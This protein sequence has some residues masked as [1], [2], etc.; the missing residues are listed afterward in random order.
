LQENLAPSIEY[1]EFKDIIVEEITVTSRD[2]EQIPLSLIY[3]K[4]LKKDGKTP[5]LIDSYG[6]YG[7]S[8]AP[9]SQDFIYCGRA[10]EE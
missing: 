5:V 6:S 9:F 4:N 2:G 10:K 1:P 3:N 8:Q 7:K